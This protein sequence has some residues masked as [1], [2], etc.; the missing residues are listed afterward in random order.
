MGDP[1][2]VALLGGRGLERALSERTGVPVTATSAADHLDVAQRLGLDGALVVG[3]SVVPWPQAVDLHA[4]GSA[5]LPAYTG[6]VYWH[7]LPALADALASAIAPGARS[8]AH[9]MLTAPDPGEDADPG[10]VVFLRE[11]AEAVA[12]RV[13]LSSR[14]IAW[15]GTTRT[16]TAAD[17]LRSVVE[18]H[19]YRDVVECPVAPGT[20]G[21]PALLELAED[22]GCRL[23]TVDLGRATLLDL[24]TEVV[25]TVA[26]HELDE[27]DGAEMDTDSGPDEPGWNR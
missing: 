13:E 25:L 24:L 5:S 17:A 20:G 23:T 11:V 27:D 21:D 26:G 10:D 16:P 1:L 18:V 19:G 4:E 22:L 12:E 6:V 2:A 7:A 9:V 3:L 15:R 8:G 14:S